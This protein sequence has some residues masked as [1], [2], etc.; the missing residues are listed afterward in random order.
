MHKLLYKWQLHGLKKSKNEKQEWE[1]AYIEI[2]MAPQKLKTPIKTKFASKVFWTNV[3]PCKDSHIMIELCGHGLY[4][5]PILQSLVI[6]WCF[7]Y[8]HYFN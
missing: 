5:E 3:G 7:N 1:K 8:Y 4:Y 6:V 2:G